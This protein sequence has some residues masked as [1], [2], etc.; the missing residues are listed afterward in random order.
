MRLIVDFKDMAVSEGL[1]PGRIFRYLFDLR[2]ID[3]FLKKDFQEVNKKDIQVL[4]GK[5]ECSKRFS[6]STV[7]DLKI[8][9]RKFYTW[10]RDTNEI[11]EEVN[12]YKTYSKY[13]AIKTPEDMLTEEEVQ[14]MIEFCSNPRDKAFIA[15]LYESGCRIGEI[16]LLRINQIKFDEYGA[17]L[18]VNGKTGFRRVR[19]VAAVPYITEWLNNHPLKN[20]PKEYLWIGRNL[21]RWHY[22]SMR[23]CLRRIAKRANINKRVNPHN[24]RHSR[25]THLA[26]YLTEAQMKEYFGWIQASKMASIYVHL[27]GRDVDNAILN[28]YGIK[29]KEEDKETLLKPKNCRRCGESNQATNKFCAKCGLA[30]DEEARIEVIRK[31]IERKEADDIMDYL[32]DDPEF[33]KIFLRKI[34]EAKSLREATNPAK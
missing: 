9:L 18:L 3:E 23:D 5:L 15:T 1:S 21:T 20:N 27:S 16:L 14:K 10:L 17:I 8:T 12:W 19:V 11:P 34:Y 31:T 28:V 26:N 2:V 24:H 13:K 30:L 7:R 4:V 32:V 29:S 25:A 22:N 33:R 6:R